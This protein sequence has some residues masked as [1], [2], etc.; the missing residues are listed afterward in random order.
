VSILSARHTTGD[1]RGATPVLG[2]DRGAR[3][4]DD[5]W[6]IRPE[7]IREGEVDEHMPDDATACLADPV[8]GT[9]DLLRRTAQLAI[10]HRS[11]L[12]DL[13]VA[14]RTTTAVLEAAL[15]GPMPRDG[16]PAISINGDLAREVSPSWPTR[17]TDVDGSLDAIQC[18]LTSSRHEA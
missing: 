6:H 15:G 18:C 17:A 12:L 8:T 16:E 2:V 4:R 5:G 11:C 7:K 3:G 1:R 14:P 13:A 10:E 9:A